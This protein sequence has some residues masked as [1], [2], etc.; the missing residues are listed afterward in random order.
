MSNIVIAEHSVA[1][2]A[3]LRRRFGFIPDPMIIR[4]AEVYLNGSSGAK[5][6]G[7]TDFNVMAALDENTGGVS[8][9]F[10]LLV[11]RERIPLINYGDTFD[12]DMADFNAIETLLG[13]LCQKVEIGY[14]PYQEIKAGALI[15]L[16]K[17][18]FARLQNMAGVILEMDAF[19]W[20][21]RPALEASPAS[22]NAALDE[23]HGRLKGI[24]P[25]L[26]HSGI[27]AF[28]LGGLIF[29]GMAQAANAVHHVQPKKTLN[30]RNHTKYLSPPYWQGHITHPSVHHTV[31]VFPYPDQSVL[32]L[33]I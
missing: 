15:N 5:A 4:A 17:M 33:Y 24:N 13:D 8:D 16:A 31:L 11:T 3:E 12:R 30:G 32:F 23:A 19:G 27:A 28:L 22:S 1:G 26:S 6:L 25:D 20:E 21:W 2:W 18:D 14:Q 7:R 10:D 29:S 9:F